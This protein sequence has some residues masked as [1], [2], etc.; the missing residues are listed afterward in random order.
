[1]KTNTNELSLNEMEQVNG[2]V[3]TLAVIGLVSACIS[4]GVGVTKF[5]IK[6]YKD[7]T[8]ED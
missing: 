5:G 3:A 2:G 4:L 7:I 8:K 6:I 1:M